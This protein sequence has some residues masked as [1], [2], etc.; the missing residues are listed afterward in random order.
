VRASAIAS[1]I[2]SA[3][4]RMIPGGASG[5]STRCRDRNVSHWLVSVIDGQSRCNA[6][7]AIQTPSRSRSDS[8]R[9][10]AAVIAIPS[11]KDCLQCSTVIG[12]VV[13]VA[14]VFFVAV[15]GFLWQSQRYL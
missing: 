5:Y 8:S 2:R 9:R 10:I 11:A 1:V 6:S 4:V 7:V 13:L 3:I 14:V 15:G 12:H